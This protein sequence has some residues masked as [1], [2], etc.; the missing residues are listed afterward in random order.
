M[1]SR[2]IS[3]VVVVALVAAAV[4]L[5]V[6]LRDDDGDTEQA[7]TTTTQEATT[8]KKDKERKQPKPEPEVTTIVVKGGQPVGGVQE[9]D[10]TR[11]DDV[12]F[13][14]RSDVA[15]EVHVHGYDL[16]E[17]VAPGKVASFD[18]PAEI[19][20]GFEVELETTHTQIAGL[21]VE[22]G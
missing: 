9:L 22:P 12:R 11:G 10:Y 14:V 13:D 20:G 3:A 17:D 15:D 8:A 5:F 19:D 6:V 7:A 21:T 4:V 2:T 1:Q 16:F 18:F